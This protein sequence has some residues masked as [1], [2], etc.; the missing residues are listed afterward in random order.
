M[1]FFEKTGGIF[2][3]NL[4]TLKEKSDILPIYFLKINAVKK[5]SKSF[6]GF[7]ERCR[8]VQGRKQKR[9]NTLWSGFPESIVGE[10]GCAR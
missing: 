6:C 3:K 4:L 5:R 9:P 8:L 1:D 7:T 2:R 10:D